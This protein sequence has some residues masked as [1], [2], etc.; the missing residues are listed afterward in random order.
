MEAVHPNHHRS[1]SLVCQ[2]DDPK[3]PL[4]IPHGPNLA[5]NLA[6]AILDRMHVGVDASVE[7]RSPQGGDIIDRLP[8]SCGT[9]DCLLKTG[10]CQL[11]LGQE[12]INI[13]SRV[14][15]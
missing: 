7:Y 12:P 10:I 15:H 9:I 2:P 4:W 8:T 6:S 13:N 1:P 11:A 14:R 3:T 5:A